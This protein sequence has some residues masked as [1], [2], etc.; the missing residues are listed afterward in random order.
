[1][2]P[3]FDHHIHMDG[4]NA[5]DYELMAVAGVRKILVPCAAS[6]ERRYGRASYGARFDRV[7]DFEHARAARFD[8]ELLAGVSVHAAD[9]GDYESALE[10]IDEVAERLETP[11][12]RALG[13]VSL[14]T[15]SDEEIDI[16]ERQLGLAA[17]R[18]VPVMIESPPGLEDFRSLLAVLEKAIAA[19][20]ADRH[21]LCLLDVDG[22]KLSL[23][24]P[25]ELG[26]YGLPVSPELD[27]LF[28]LR[29]KLTSEEVVAI[30]ER[31]GPAHLML[32]SGLHFGSADP[33]GL[34][35]TVLRLQ[36]RGVPAADLR[37][38]AHDNADR[39]FDAAAA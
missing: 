36:L 11:H 25:L 9:I 26:A 21:R 4:R 29:E 19:G 32:N 13:E 17:K 1:M 2:I 28:C 34:A 37:L 12:V 20:R 8:V 3:I 5:D 30:L 27:G 14:R 6:N 31:F 18:R 10:G 23:A 7:V 39:F 33:L 24:Y 38:I 16:F 35:K 22:E 15:F